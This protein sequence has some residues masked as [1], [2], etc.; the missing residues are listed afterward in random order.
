MARRSPTGRF[1]ALRQG[2][3]RE[4]L[5]IPFVWTNSTILSNAVNLL[6]SLN[7]AALALRP[8]TIVRSRGIMQLR[9]DQAAGTEAQAVNY[10]HIVVSEEAVTAGVASVPTPLSEAGSD[11]HVYEQLASSFVLSSA[12]GID[13]AAGVMKTF[14][15][16]AMRK[17]DFGEDLIA[18]AEVPAT[19]ISEGVIF[20]TQARVLV[21][22]H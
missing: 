19:G 11:W 8:F 16:K 18:V 12:V 14:D 15:S 5:W 1:P 20:R 17:V 10:G 13:A 3:R 2:R 7:A 4:S 6:I 21:K 9:S 22:L